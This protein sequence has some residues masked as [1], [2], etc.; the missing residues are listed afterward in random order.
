MST[1]IAEA[2]AAL[3][4][5]GL[6][7]IFEVDGPLLERWFLKTIINM[8]V[9]QSLPIGLGAAPSRPTM[10]LVEMVYGR[11]PIA[12]PRGLFCV[13]RPGNE[14]SF[15]EGFQSIFIH[16]HKRYLIG[17]LL[18]FRTMVFGFNFEDARIPPQLFDKMP[19]FQGSSVIHPFKELKFENTNV[20]LRLR[21]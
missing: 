12:S 16:Q 2:L 1:R 4:R 13:A 14:H 7:V 19:A 20:S 18:A 5:R 9:G 10:E 11:R 3:P 15:G 8:A 21:W 6:W 17:G